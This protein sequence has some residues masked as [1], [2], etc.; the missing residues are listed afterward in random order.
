MGDEDEEQPE[1]DLVWKKY[2]LKPVEV[3][4]DN[5]FVFPCNNI[6]GILLLKNHPFPSSTII[7]NKYLVCVTACSGKKIRGF[8][9]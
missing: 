8:Y 3:S 5:P 2:F 7:C 6:R 1:N 9:C 4:F